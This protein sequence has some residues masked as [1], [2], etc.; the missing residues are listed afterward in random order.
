MLAVASIPGFC[1]P[2]GSML[3]LSTAGVVAGLGWALIRRGRGFGPRLALSCFVLAA[4]AMLALSGTY[5][6]LD[7]RICALIEED[8]LHLL[9]SRANGEQSALARSGRMVGHDVGQ[10]EAQRWDP[11]FGRDRLLAQSPE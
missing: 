2:F 4:I 5:H 8:L 7:D 11:D 6:L 3:H 10:V 9:P 1:E